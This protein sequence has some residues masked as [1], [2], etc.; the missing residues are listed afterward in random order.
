MSRKLLLPLLAVCVTL[1]AGVPAADASLGSRIGAVAGKVAGLQKAIG[2]IQ[3][4]NT[5][6]TAAINR[7]G[8]RIAD[9]QKAIGD[10]QALVRGVIATATDSLTKLQTGLTD[11]AAAVQGPNIAGQLGAAGSAAPGAG[12]AATPSTLPTGTLYRQI[13][14]STGGAF[15]AGAPIG[16]RTWVKMP[17]VVAIGYSNKYACTSAGAT[18]TA[19]GA[20]YTVTCTSP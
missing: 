10:L 3:D 2:H 13:V 19:T 6:Q 8:D 9:S 5:G 18:D 20:G 7:N 17:D 11:L 1:V 16:A 15:G 12:N 4:T 14:L